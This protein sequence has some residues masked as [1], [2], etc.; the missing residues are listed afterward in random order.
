MTEH[1]KLSIQET[2]QLLKTGEI[3]PTTLVESHLAR[4]ENTEHKLNSFITITSENALIEAE[5]ATSEIVEKG[6]RSPL[7]G[8]PIGLKDLYDT[9]GVLTTVGSKIYRDRLPLADATVVTKLRKAGAIIMGKLQ[10]HEFALGATSINPHDGPARNPWD[11]TRITGGS[12]GGSG[13][14]VASGQCMAALGT[15]T[16]GSVRITA[17]LCGIVGI[18]P[19]FG[20]IGRTGVYPLSWT[21][22]TVGPLTRTVEDAAIMLDEI[23]GF[24]PSDKSYVAKE[25]ESFRENIGK[26]IAGKKIAIPQEYFYDVLDEEVLKS[27]NA[28]LETFRDLGAFSEYVS[29]PMLDHSLSISGAI[30][31]AEAASVHENNIRQN[32]DMIGE[33]VR[34]KLMQGSLMPAS[35]YIKAQR[36]RTIF[37]DQI[38]DVFSKYDYIVSPTVALGAPRIDDPFVK[39]DSKEYSVLALMARL[40]RP[41]NICGLPTITIP[42][43]MTKKNL[44][45]G[46]QIT[47]R[48]FRDVDV[49]QL[50]HA[51]E[52]VTEWSKMWPDL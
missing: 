33:D 29:I 49:I 5:K 51:Y 36:A 14:S 46:L 43:G 27:F 15:D 47:G 48:N 18:K 31:L 7:H 35:D 6:V 3:S 52:N 45:I 11:T 41:F 8:I 17:S 32:H 19:S 4:I 25:S 34:L 24:D 38:N 12:S 30:M 9:K 13:S 10:M 16:G 1:W 20:R 44:P 2:S 22:D 26:P 28:S 21:M 50:A 40:T 42:C 23:A 39:I 37:N